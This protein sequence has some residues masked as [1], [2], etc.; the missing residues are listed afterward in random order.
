MMRFITHHLTSIKG[1]EIFPM[2]SLMIFVS[3]FAIV[4]IRVWK[5]TRSESDELSNIP[6]TDDEAYQETLSTNDIK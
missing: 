2:L 4:L 5:M 1:V 3:F 6:F